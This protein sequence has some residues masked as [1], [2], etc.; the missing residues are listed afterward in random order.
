MDHVLLDLDQN[1]PGW[2]HRAINLLGSSASSFAN[3]VSDLGLQ[4]CIENCYEDS[5]EELYGDLERETHNGPDAEIVDLQS[6]DLMEVYSVLGMWLIQNWHSQVSADQIA[7]IVMAAECT[8]MRVARLRRAIFAIPSSAQAILYTIF[9][10]LARLP[11]TLSRP[12]SYLSLSAR[13]APS[14]SAK[15]TNASI[16]ATTPSSA[17]IHFSPLLINMFDGTFMCN[18]TI[19]GP[20]LLAHDEHRARELTDDADLVDALRAERAFAILY[21]THR[22][23]FEFVNTT[24]FPQTATASSASP[25]SYQNLQSLLSSSLARSYPSRQHLLANAAPNSNISSPHKA[26]IEAALQQQQSQ[27][28]QPSQPS[29]P[30][31][32]L[33][34]TPPPPLEIDPTSSALATLACEPSKNHPSSSSSSESTDSTQSAL[35]GKPAPSP[36]ATTVAPDGLGSITQAEIEEMRKE[37]ADLRREVYENEQ[38]CQRRILEVMDLCSYLFH[39]SASHMNIQQ[40]LQPQPA[41]DLGR[42]AVLHVDDGLNPSR[43]L[44]ANTNAHTQP[45]S[46][47]KRTRSGQS[48]PTIEAANIPPDLFHQVSGALASASIA[49]GS[50]RGNQ[51]FSGHY[52][53]EFALPN[54]SDVEAMSSAALVSSESYIL[55][56]DSQRKRERGVQ[57]SS[58]HSSSHASGATAP[59][60]INRFFDAE[61]MEL[62]EPDSLR[63]MFLRAI[64]MSESND[65]P[66]ADSEQANGS[67]K[68]FRDGRWI[69]ESLV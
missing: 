31:Q 56:S 55:P 68:V 7:D 13:C 43:P 22:D 8:V 42:P 4:G 65:F 17:N 19:F 33:V 9:R 60:D 32:P 28:T 37:I 39:M 69:R 15:R 66:D 40:S 2:V 45:P 46:S 30:S 21:N 53:L 23:V 36:Y 62:G 14:A 38:N 27:P 49:S 61:P 44:Y 34:S 11:P 51:S 5:L 18:A 48:L 12:N 20:L 3:L 25:Q 26:I 67:H 24:A 64:T 6:Y 41:S 58:L 52:N 1:V 29:Q 47:T 16:L 54:V 63:D 50:Q 35:P 57:F 59:I 10:R